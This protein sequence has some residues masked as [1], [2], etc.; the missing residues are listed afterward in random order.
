MNGIPLHW[1]MHIQTLMGT[2]PGLSMTQHDPQMDE[3]INVQGSIAQTLSIL[4]EEHI[5][6]VQKHVKHPNKRL[7]YVGTL[8]WVG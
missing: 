8:F 1:I 6:S 5:T 2:L 3:F 7:Q 4:F